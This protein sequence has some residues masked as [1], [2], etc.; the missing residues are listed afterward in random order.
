MKERE[1]VMVADEAWR[2]QYAPEIGDKQWVWRQASK[3]ARMVRANKFYY[4]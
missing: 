2:D 3:D 4:Q 1:E